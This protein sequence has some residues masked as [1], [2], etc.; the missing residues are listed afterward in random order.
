M[1]TVKNK[2]RQMNV[3]HS[4]RPRHHH[5]VRSYAWCC[6]CVQATSDIAQR[7]RRY[8]PIIKVHIVVGNLSG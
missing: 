1:D 7:V 6:V 2:H 4:R 3:I 8:L 5:V